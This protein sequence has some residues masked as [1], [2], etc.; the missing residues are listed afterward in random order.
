[1]LFRIRPREFRA[2]ARP[3]GP[4]GKRA[5]PTDSPPGFTELVV[6]FGSPFRLNHPPVEEHGL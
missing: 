4:S 2:K 3:E 6:V 1:V 5:S